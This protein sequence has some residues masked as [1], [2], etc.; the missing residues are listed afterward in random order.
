MILIFNIG[1]LLILIGFFITNKN[2]LFNL[3]ISNLFLLNKVLKNNINYYIIFIIFFLYIINSSLQNELI[4]NI[5][6]IEF[7]LYYILFIFFYYSNT[8]YTYYKINTLLFNTILFIS[9]ITLLT[10][11]HV[12]TLV[13][14]YLIL[15]I[16]GVCVYILICHIKHNQYQIT[17]GLKYFILNII[18][19]LFFCIGCL[20]YYIFLN[21][22]NLFDITFY[23]FY[24][25]CIN[26][27][28]LYYISCIFIIGSL[29]FKI[30]AIPF[31]FWI[32]D[33]Y[34]NI[35]WP[36]LIYLST[37][38]FSFYT[39]LIQFLYT[40]LCGYVIIYLNILL[41]LCS[42]LLLFSGPIIG[43]I[44]TNLKGLIGASSITISGFFILSLINITNQQ[45]EFIFQYIIIYNIMLG[46]LYVLIQQLNI[47]LN[48]FHT[49]YNHYLLLLKGICYIDASNS[50][51]LLIIIFT[52]LGIPLF[53]LFIFKIS[54]L[55]IFFN[56]TLFNL[57]LILLLL[58]STIITSYLY[59]RII[60]FYYF[61]EFEKNGM[62]KYT[63]IYLKNKYMILFNENIILTYIIL[64]NLYTFSINSTFNNISLLT[65]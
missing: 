45:F 53:S 46:L 11:L 64:L 40:I 31:N 60:K 12:T 50:V 27:Q 13:E 62:T 39:Y 22:L 4:K 32:I 3:N 2:N 51:L 37:I 47:I 7:L 16:Q 21:S 63:S 25:N 20:C 61:Y 41:L 55:I 65:Y 18:S 33:I 17:I 48:S 44:Q 10:L 26:N 34:L 6:L 1:C 8:L 19:S 38:Q 57:F 35:E 49:K 30:Y 36:I 24:S 28:T 54:F 43:C 15:E 14:I 5:T 59:L 23:L 42:I 9:S 56:T 29:L 58:T 52:I